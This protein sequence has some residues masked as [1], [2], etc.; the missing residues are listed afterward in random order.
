[1]VFEFIRSIVQGRDDAKAA[2]AEREFLKT[3]DLIENLAPSLQETITFGVE[4]ELMTRAEEYRR[5]LPAHCQQ[6]KDILQFINSKGLKF[7]AEDYFS[8]ARIHKADTDIMKKSAGFAFDLIGYYL[9]SR[10]WQ[11]MDHTINIDAPGLGATMIGLRIETRIHAFVKKY[12]G[13]LPR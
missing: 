7:L 13:S 1:M 6:D 12:E 8:H 4:H 3:M 10:S 2:I 9:L 11:D 5:C